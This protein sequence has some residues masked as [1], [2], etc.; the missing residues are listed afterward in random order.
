MNDN[1]TRNPEQEQPDE[2]RAVSV[3]ADLDAL[4][5]IRN[6]FPFEDE[7]QRVLQEY[8]VE[9]VARFSVAGWVDMVCDLFGW[10]LACQGCG[11]DTDSDHV[12][13]GVSLEWLLPGDDNNFVRLELGDDP[14]LLVGDREITFAALPD[15]LGDLRYTVRSAV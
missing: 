12:S 7:G 3:L 13:L 10:R 4:M 8:A 2:L 11:A 14:T 6:L 1:L 9:V 15:T 5:Q